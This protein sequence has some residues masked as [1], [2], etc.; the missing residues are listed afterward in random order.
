MRDPM[1]PSENHQ[2]HVVILKQACLSLATGYIFQENILHLI[3]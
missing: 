3:F 1:R 2:L